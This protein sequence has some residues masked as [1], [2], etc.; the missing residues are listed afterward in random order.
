MRRSGSPFLRS[1]AIGALLWLAS[2]PAG[3]RQALDLGSP[4]NVAPGVT[5][6][7]LTD[8]SLLNPPA[9][10]SVWLLKLDLAS[11]DLRAALASGEIM[12]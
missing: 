5:L 2:V 9:P 7:H 6:V 1:A 8:Q 12:W 10:V 11:A 3:T 4:R